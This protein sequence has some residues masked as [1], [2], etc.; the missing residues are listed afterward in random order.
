MTHAQPIIT[1]SRV[2]AYV[3][4][5]LRLLGW[6]LGVILRIGARGRSV[7]L[8][9]LLSRAELAVECIIFLKAVAL[10]GPPPQRRRY[11]RS[12]PRGF[13]RAASSQRSF[14]RS[15]KIR[16]RKS[17]PLARILALLDAL[18]HPERAVAYFLKQICKGLR[19]SRLIPVAP[20]AAALGC[21]PF[22]GAA[23]SI[24]SS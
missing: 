14:F 4:S 1:A 8:K 9:H 19:L 3:A 6:L 21:G 23:C 13:R 22:F 5:A 17:A 7:R 12:T 24:D 15:V 16:A 20:S 18:A 2:E 10:Y 11:P